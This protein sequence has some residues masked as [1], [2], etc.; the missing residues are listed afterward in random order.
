MVGPNGGDVTGTPVSGGPQT[1]Q[2]DSDSRTWG[3]LAHL[4]ALIGFIIPFGNIAAPLVVWLI[5]RDEMAFVNDQGREAL[6]FNISIA[7]YA[8]AAGFLALI[9]LGLL[10][11]LPILVAL[12]GAVFAII[13]GVQANK[14]EY[15]RYPLTIR[16]VK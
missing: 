1:G 3:M 15:Y 12:A 16:L 11:F 2:L 10:F 14:G 8:L 5:K 9:T 13:A 6:N 7:I 4:S